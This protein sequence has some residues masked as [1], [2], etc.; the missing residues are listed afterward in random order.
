MHLSKRGY[1]ID[2]CVTDFKDGVKLCKLL[3]VIGETTLSKVNAT[4]RMRIQQTENIDKV[5]KFIASRDVKLT[6]I[7]PTDI[8]DGNVKLTLG[9]I[10]TLILRFAISELSAE[11]MSAKQGLLLW[12]QKK[13]EPYPVKVDN[14]SE[15]FKDGRVFCALIHRHRPDLIDWEAV[16][17]N[18][19]ENLDKA[20]DICEEHLGIP[21]L[22]D[23]DDIVS[24]PR[25]DEKSVMTYVAQMYRVFSQG[26]Q[27]EKAGKR[28]GK[29]LDFLKATQDMIFDY[30]TRA[31]ALDEKIAAAKKTLN[32]TPKSTYA[33]LKEQNA[34]LRAY[35]VGEKREILAEQSELATLL[36]N[37]Q[38]KLRSLKKPAYT[39]PAGLS[40]KDFEAKV[41]DLT[42]QERGVK[43][44]LSQAIKA[45]LEKLRK[46]F[47]D[48]ANK[49]YDQLM[50]Y[51]AVLE[52]TADKPFEEQLKELQKNLDEMQAKVPGQLPKIEQAE[53]LCEEAN[54][55]D[56][57][58]SDHTF[59]DL[60]FMYK[61]NV[62][63]YNKKIVFVQATLD[64]ASS[65][66]S[67][68]QMQEFRESF[69]HF[70]ENKNGAL[71]KLEFKACL[72][73]MGLADVDLA[74]GADKKYDQLW[75]KIPKNAS[76][77]VEFDAYVNYMKSVTED[78]VTQEQFAEQM[79]I[80]AGGKDFVTE[81]DMIKAGMTPDQ[82]EYVK[83]N[84]P[85]KHD[86]YD[87]NA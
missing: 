28:A 21:K 84:M 29:Y 13:C 27:A 23:T 7:G 19:R 16:G 42:T 65:G 82:I 53:R 32:I 86:G 64:E 46:D 10:W 78:A 47:A 60:E 1:K 4:P 33:E 76:S 3:E 12:C 61:Q 35:R 69:D 51:R 71:D 40:T 2:S 83:T 5:L 74:G 22:L 52:T 77:E 72:S 44:A 59:E 31:K 9:L 73:S 37:I 66:V 56:N 15:S 75:A 36:S 41:N 62:S 17:H 14:F 11:G 25:P 55:E 79:G 38:S 68:E 81:N 20:F 80:V 6:G 24:M 43:N 49:L 30:E 26:D 48:P 87:F 63:L 67:A 34:Q 57:E 58:Y 54:I 39:P 18:D 70:D 85:K 50:A 8:A 45:C